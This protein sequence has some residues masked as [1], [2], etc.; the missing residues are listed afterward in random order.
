MLPAKPNGPALDRRTAPPPRSTARQPVAV[1]KSVDL[2]GRRSITKELLGERS[3]RRAQQARAAAT[4]VAIALALGSLLVTGTGVA[5]SSSMHA[6]NIRLDDPQERRLFERLLCM[7]GDCQR[8]TL[9]NCGCSWAD[10]MRGELRG[11]LSNGGTPTEI[12]AQ[13]RARFGARAIAVPSDAGLDRALWAVPV[14][15][16][17]AAGGGLF[18]LGRKWMK[19]RTAGR[20][21]PV[22]ALSGAAP[23]TASAP[24]VP[25]P[26]DAKL[27]DELAKLDGA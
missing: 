6:A 27:D 13:Y 25:D 9:A 14:G 17:V 24:A 7:C 16:I 1:R 26:Y 22:A 4:V 8:L 2:G 11:N 23:S 18:W 12:E 15:A 10:D 20:S 3:A 21:A 5:Q 19:R